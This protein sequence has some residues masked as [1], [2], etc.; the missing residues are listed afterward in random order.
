MRH[1]RRVRDLTSDLEASPER[2]ELATKA[3]AG[4]LGLGWRLGISPEES[5]AL[6]AEGTDAERFRRDL[7]YAG[8][9]M[10]SGR[11]RR[12]ARRISRSG[13]AGRLRPVIEGAR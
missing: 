6:H 2:D 9:L 4:I 3:G 5:A 12:G 7:Y 8:S 13:S 11:E 10:H 1:W